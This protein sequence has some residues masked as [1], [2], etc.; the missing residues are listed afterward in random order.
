[1]SICSLACRKV[2]RRLS[3]RKPNGCSAGRK[4]LPTGKGNFASLFSTLVNYT[5]SIARRVF[6]ND[7]GF[8]A[9]GSGHY[10]FR[11]LC[12]GRVEKEMNM[13]EAVIVAAARSPIGRASKG[14]L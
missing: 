12:L 3:T 2:D 1:M 11:R 5:N 4:I 10:Q 7:K 9:G 8:L 13:P 6:L 14:S